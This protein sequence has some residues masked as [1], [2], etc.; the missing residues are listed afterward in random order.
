MST[1][2]AV[3]RLSDGRFH[4]LCDDLIRRWEPRYARLRTHGLNEAGESVVGQPDSY[5]G[6]SAATCRIAV[7]YTVQRKGWWTKL[8]E[9]VKEAVAASPNVEEIVAA[10][11]WDVDRH[12]PT[13]GENLD[14][15]DKAKAAA[16]KAAFSIRH[17]PEIA[18]LLDTD[19][20][21]L[22]HDHL[23]IPYSR[24]SHQAILAACRRATATALD[25]LEVHGRYEPSRYLYRE[26]DRELFRLW[27]RAIRGAKSG[28]DR[29]EA[30]R[31]I[32][33]V[34]DSGFGKTSLLCSFAA[35][36]S[37]CQPVLFIQARHLMFAGEDSL[38][39][40][41]VRSLE[42]VLAPE[43]ARGEEAAVVYHLRHARLTVVLDGLDEAGN[44]D[45]VRRAVRCWLDS[46]LGRQ[47][48]LIL[49]SRREFWRLASERSWGPW[50][51][52]TRTDER[53]AA[54]PDAR[55]A[56]ARSAPSAGV[57][58]P[59]P[60]SPA[61]LERAW[62]AGERAP[63]ELSAL[64]DE[65]REELRHPFTLRAFLALS[66]GGRPVA[67]LSRTDIMSAWLDSRLRAEEDAEARITADVY[68][69]ALV[70]V[71]RK[72]AEGTAGWIAV[73][74]LGGVPRFDASRPPGPVVERLLRAGILESLPGH[75]D[76]LRFVFETVQDFFLAE[77]D[78]ATVAA[79][80]Q[81]VALTLT[82]GSFS[83]VYIRLERL[84]RSLSGSPARN[85]FLD[86]LADLDPVRA[87]VVM[88]ADPSA[89]AP[90]VRKSV[91]A[92]LRK[93]LGSRH[94]VRAAFTANLLGRLECEEARKAL[95]DG[96]PPA[97]RCPFS[98]LV[99]A[100]R[101]FIRLG[102]IERV[103]FVYAYPCFGMDEPYYF[104]DDIQRMRAADPAFKA[105]LGDYAVVQLD[106]PS[107]SPEHIRAVTVL[108]YL[109]DARLAEHLDHRLAA[110]GALQ[111][112]EN[113]AL[114]A[115]GTDTAAAVF[116]ASLRGAAAA[117][118]QLGHD[119][120]GKARMEVHINVSSK[121]GDLRYLITP[122]FEA[123]LEALI[124]DAN[125]EVAELAT[126]LAD[127]SKSPRLLH[128]SLVVHA[129]R[130]AF[131]ALTTDQVADT[132]D[133]PTWVSWWNTAESDAVRGKLLTAM[134]P[135]PNAKTE[136]IL[137]ECL[138]NPLFRPAAA[139][140]L[141]RMGS[142]Q[143]A[144]PLR[145]LLDEGLRGREAF[146]VIRAISLLADPAA[147]GVLA[148]M[149]QDATG[150]ELSIIVTALGAIGTAES[151]RV[152]V[153]L[154]YAGKE[155]D[156]LVSGL[157]LHGS[158]T[159]VARMVAEARKDGRG[160]HWLANLL[161]SSFMRLWGWSVG[162][163]HTHVHDGEL[164]AYLEEQ[165]HEFR[166]PAKWDLLHAVEQIDS[167]NVRRL[168]RKIAKRKGTPED[169][170]IWADNELRASGLAARDLMIRE[171]A[172]AVEH[173]VLE[174]ISSD[175]RRAW[176]AQDL[177]KLPRDAVASRL[178]AALSAADTDEQRATVVRLLGHFGNE[179]DAV[180]VRGFVE[181]DSDDLANAAY[182]ALCRLTD[183]LLVPADWGGP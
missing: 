68:R 12:G 41:V 62:A 25:E 99:S 173:F 177:V 171:D 100:A 146:A 114:M 89:Y 78:V 91:V 32:A 80:P 144:A 28:A 93:G 8:V 178:R 65:V 51:A 74:Q 66:A 149:A 115:L 179:E 131:R 105:A 34:N 182:E 117:L 26:A 31:L 69:R 98:L 123:A 11:P 133:P 134:S 37:A 5:V 55:S 79:D 72:I 118:A 168:L 6:D 2:D 163:F 38:V 61:E 13:K 47:S 94:R 141:G 174:A 88:Q 151:E 167:E 24:L 106:A 95:L 125:E 121:T 30:I 29:E 70:E 103:A 92:G 33:L 169:D 181:S 81:A 83:K 43:L 96:V 145:R 21:D 52:E 86:A 157:F 136:R 139:R 35:A 97:E 75:A 67:A 107:G 132:V 17:G 16:G 10:L 119:D 124:G 172:A 46:R 104:R 161:R 36:L 160:P 153:Q 22:R 23:G 54:T 154:L 63:A 87:A 27:Q 147:V 158:P 156:W 4:R 3:Q 165:E 150:D 9:D 14:W 71:A 122:P 116:T 77:G 152:L 129:G 20:Q 140:H 137:I 15:L 159:A 102:C 49:S 111:G 155:A 19:H 127:T 148:R 108:A 183:P 85:E 176:V 58:L 143:A 59:G 135:V 7:C 162:R 126:D 128:R 39:R 112:Y 120:G 40:A 50:M 84:G 1:L 130:R 110:N 113:H 45:A 166:G 82:E 109:G 56:L 57:R 175:K 18:R 44:A 48:V 138:D 170:V 90:A 73:D 101:A 53:E 42:G 164:I 76:R 142:H 64:P 60:F 180:A